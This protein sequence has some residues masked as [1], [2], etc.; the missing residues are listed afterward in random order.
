MMIYS[1]CLLVSLNLFAFL[2][3]KISCVSRDMHFLKKLMYDA[4]VGEV[5]R[6]APVSF[7]HITKERNDA[8]I[9]HIKYTLDPCYYVQC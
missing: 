4:D 7:L 2:S 9:Y 1:F 3:A 5:E 8:K 6:C